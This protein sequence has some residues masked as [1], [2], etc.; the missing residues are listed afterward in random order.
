LES[1][2]E[3]TPEVRQ[4]RKKVGANGL[5]TVMTTVLSSTAFTFSRTLSLVKPNW[6]RMKPGDLFSVT[7]RWKE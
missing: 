3:A 2:I 6:V 4:F 5:E 7:A 1:T